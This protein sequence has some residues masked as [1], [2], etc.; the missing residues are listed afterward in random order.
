[1]KRYCQTLDLKNDENLIQE[2]M[3]WHSPEHFWPEIGAGIREAENFVAKYQ[4]VLPDANSAGKRQL[5]DCIFK[6]SETK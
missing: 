4:Q 5:T 2:Y 6:L 1:M 3:Y